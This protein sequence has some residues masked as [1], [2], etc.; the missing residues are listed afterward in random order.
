VLSNADGCRYC[1]D[2]CLVGDT[3][4]YDYGACFGACSNAVEA[5]CLARPGCRAAYAGASFLMCLPTAPSGALH[6]GA[7]DGLDAYECSRHDN[8]SAAYVQP[9]SGSP[10]FDRC[11]DE[12]VPGAG[13]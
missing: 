10:T 11:F 12:A 9:G 2:S 1:F 3:R 7:C 6:D 5:D 13:L 8:C 4:R